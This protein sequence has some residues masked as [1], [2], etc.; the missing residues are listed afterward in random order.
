MTIAPRL[1][2][3]LVKAAVTYEVIEHPQ[4]PSASRTAEAAHAPGDRLAKAVVL[5]DRQGYLLAV[6][7]ST[8]RL[9]LDALEQ[10]LGRQFELAR[11]AEVGKLFPDCEVGAVPPLGDAYG[12]DVM[13]D[14]SLTQQPEVYVE[15]GDHRRLVRLSGADFA[16]LTGGA[17]RA[18]FSHHT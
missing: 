4:A 2:E 12:L 7:P 16:S 8:H 18:R 10:L 3:A 6:V 11:E 17:R 9:D 1:R 13:V 5:Q 15:A 14:E